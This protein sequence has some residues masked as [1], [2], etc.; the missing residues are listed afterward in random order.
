MSLKYVVNDLF[1]SNDFVIFTFWVP[2]CSSAAQA[3]N[4][5]PYSMSYLLNERERE[6]VQI[7][8]ARY[9]DRFG[10][11]AIDDPDLVIFLGDNRPIG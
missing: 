6:C 9:Q 5:G 2:C 10:Q 3:K 4:D 1:N 8:S 7:A 11:R